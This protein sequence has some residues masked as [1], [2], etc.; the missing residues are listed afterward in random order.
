MQDGE[1]EIMHEG[2][3]ESPTPSN[4]AEKLAQ[5]NI[6]KDSTENTDAFC[7]GWTS[8]TARQLYMCGNHD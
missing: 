5:Q 4:V 8:F 3:S 6:R 7:D 1:D 2:E